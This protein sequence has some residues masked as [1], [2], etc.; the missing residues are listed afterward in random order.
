MCIL[1]LMA[2]W[3]RLHGGTGHTDARDHYGARN[4]RVSNPVLHNFAL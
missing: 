1:L 4:Q 3:S 2:C